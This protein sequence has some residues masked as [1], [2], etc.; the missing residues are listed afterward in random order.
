MAVSIWMM[1]SKQKLPSQKSQAQ[2]V[3]RIS[4]LNSLVQ[5]WEYVLL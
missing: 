1:K 3:L 5:T 2:F 4:V